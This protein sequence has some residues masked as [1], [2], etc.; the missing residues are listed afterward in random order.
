M[1]TPTQAAPTPAF[2]R[3]GG[4]PQHIEPERGR[5]SLDILSKGTPWSDTGDSQG[6]KLQQSSKPND[7]VVPRIW[8]SSTSSRTRPMS[9]GPW[10]PPQTP[11]IFKIQ[12]PRSPPKKAQKVPAST[13]P[14]TNPPLG[15][16][17]NSPYGSPLPQTSPLNNS[18]RP[19]K[20]F[21]SAPVTETDV[22]AN[23]SMKTSQPVMGKVPPM[24]PPVNRAV[25]PNM[26]ATRSSSDSGT[27]W[28][29]LE[30]AKKKVSNRISPFSTP[31]SSDASL[32]MEDGSAKPIDE[33][34]TQQRI[35]QNQYP[36]THHTADS[37]WNGR[38]GSTAVKSRPSDA[39]DYGFTSSCSPPD[40]FWQ[41]PS[42]KAAP[43]P[44]HDAQGDCIGRS[45]TVYAP[46]PRGTAQARPRPTNQIIR[47][48]T[49]F[50]P[51]PKRHAVAMNQKVSLSRAE[52]SYDPADYLRPRTLGAL[53]GPLDSRTEIRR[54]D[55]DDSGISNIGLGVTPSSSLGYPDASQ[56]NRR[57]PRARSGKQQIDTTYD[58]RIFDICSRHICST[59][60]LTKAWY[61][62]TGQMIFDMSHGERDFKITALA[63]K[64]SIKTEEEG[65]RVWLGSN[66]GDIQEIDLESQSVTQSKSGAH[67]RR[68]IIKIYRHQTS[69]WSLDEEGKLY[70]WLP[71]ESGLP[72][73]EYTPLSYRVPK[74]HTFSIVVKDNLWFATGKDIRIFKPSASG[75]VSFF[76]IQQP[77]QQSSVGEITSG[78]VISNQLDRVYFGHTDGK[79]SIYSTTDFACTGVI[80]VS[81][82]KINT[83]AG[84]GF[85]LWAGYNTGMVYVYD[86]RTQPWQTKKDWL[87]HEGPVL[88][89]V[90]DRSSV[91]KLGYLQVAS[92]GIDNTIRLWD[93]ALE[94][95]WLGMSL[96]VQ[97]LR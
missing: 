44:L 84:V 33:T 73:L 91:W 50:L 88:S 48:I 83:L 89:I 43:P 85:Y 10:S 20:E 18:P 17:L 16:S 71:D 3:A 28:T 25:K 52:E 97:H 64:P 79:V 87:A 14:I 75:D 53:N 49:D 72:S 74:G 4:I 21:Y 81:V 80:N 46:Q 36:P 95:D 47:S 24:P 5:S 6:K 67:G 59:G 58:T 1:K 22:N 9:M 13:P 57:P 32:D 76:V 86:T 29:T 51:P 65:L 55:K 61:I 90:A 23:R 93:G 96:L 15:K 38:N 82:Y 92:I 39:H 19:L 34:R 41:S 68:E 40:T 77:L 8:D 30:P 31:P 60:Y 54:T 2:R 94:D 42:A 12:P 62:T 7:R 45:G 78:A 37:R 35:S 11:P 27:G 70:V 66:Y 69:M 56:S 63:F 26:V